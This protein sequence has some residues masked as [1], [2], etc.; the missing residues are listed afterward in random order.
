MVSSLLWVGGVSGPLTPEL[1]AKGQKHHEDQLCG[2]AR[3]VQAEKEGAERPQARLIH[4]NL[5]K[6][7]V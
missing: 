7:C 1:N 5:E 2:R 3:T 6:E 4:S